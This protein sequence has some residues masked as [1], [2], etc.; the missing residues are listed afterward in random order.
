MLLEI[1]NGAAKYELLRDEIRKGIESE[2]DIVVLKEENAL[3]IEESALLYKLKGGVFF[4]KH[5]KDLVIDLRT[6]SK[7][8]D[9]FNL[10]MGIAF[11][12][13]IFFAIIGAIVLPLIL[14]FIMEAERKRAETEFGKTLLRVVRYTIE[15]QKLE[16]K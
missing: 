14:Y 7:Q 11:L 9:N 10:Y 2:M 13:G 4:E 1:K 8:P 16:I 6:K 5:D 3:V 12:V 15:R